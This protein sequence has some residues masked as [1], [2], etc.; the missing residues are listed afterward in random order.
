MSRL[1]RF[2]RRSRSQV[3]FALFAF[4]LACSLVF[5]VV[6]T[7]VFDVFIA[8]DD[9]GPVDTQMSDRDIE[10]AIRATA[11]A[12]G[13]GAAEFAAL[14]NYLANTGRIQEAIEYYERALELDPENADVRLDFA[15]SLADGGYRQDAELQFL[16]VIE[17]APDNPQAYYYLGELYLTWEPPRTDE[18]LREFRMAVEVG[19]DTFVAERAAERILEITGAT[20]TIMPATPVVQG[21]S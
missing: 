3:L 14:A 5:G 6:G 19:P 13:A 20:P 2:S 1:A 21:T 18:A 16:R 8:S 10:D 11:A 7:I 17:L 15:R 12:D 9:T 4:I